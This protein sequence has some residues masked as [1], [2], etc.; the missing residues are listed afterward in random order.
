MISPSEILSKIGL[1]G[2]ARHFAAVDFDAG[3]MR[4][5]CA[6]RRGKV[7]RIT[8]LI[9]ADLP[10]EID[11]EDA[12]AMGRFLA[13]TLAKASPSVK[14]IVMNVPRSQ[15]ILKPLRLPRG[16]AESELPAMIRFQVEKELPFPL[17][18]AL[19]DFTI[20]RHYAGEALPGEEDGALCVLVAAV[21]LPVVEHYRRIALTAGVKLRRLGLRASANLCCVLECLDEDDNKPLALVHVTADETEIDVL[22]GGYMEFSRSALI[23]VAPDGEGG[24]AVTERSARAVAAEISRSLRSYQAARQG[25][26]I[27]RILL[28]GQ[29]GIEPGIAKALTTR[30]GLKCERFNPAEALGLP[31][32]GGASP[33]ISALG[34]AIQ[35]KRSDMAFDFLNPRRPKARPDA[36]KLRRVFFAAGAAAVVLAAI[37]GGAVHVHRK[38]AAV[39][40][41]R[42]RLSQLKK[43]NK[44]VAKLEERFRAVQ[45]WAD[46]G[47]TVLDHWA[48]LSSILPPCTELYASSIKGGAEAQLILA[49]R[50]TDDDVITRLGETLRKAGYRHKTARVATSEN[51]LGYLYET[52]VQV[53]PTDDVKVD[54]S[55]GKGPPRPE[56]EAS[57]EERRSY[58]RSSRR[59]RRNRR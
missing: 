57:Y 34:L 21:R 56:N 30:L 5:V 59:N 11:V 2:S 17:A 33:F 37:V 12:G 31:D 29:T 47:P 51:P 8:Q 20:A 42:T 3:E 10:N 6:E 52:S 16:T 13:Q 4:V 54:L 7:V 28:A 22:S 25:E 46:Q 26:D 19:V 38:K 15:A 1:P 18:E 58:E 50:A 9:R 41:L 55:A 24:Q 43:L 48:L 53:I 23:D 27:S 32:D 14:S 35:S 40:Q 36:K 39:S 44:P 45:D 49:I